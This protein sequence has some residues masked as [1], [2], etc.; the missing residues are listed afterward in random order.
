MV[1][2]SRRAA[3]QGTTGAMPRSGRRKESQSGHD[4]AAGCFQ[5][6]GGPRPRAEALSL[7]VQCSV[8][9][10]AMTAVSRAGEG[11]ACSEG[12][13]EAELADH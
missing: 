9:G 1:A 8:A 7:D 13:T 11:C 3:A 5:T 4:A 12:R 6:A 10:L 2:V